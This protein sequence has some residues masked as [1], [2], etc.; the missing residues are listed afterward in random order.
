RVA[1]ERATEV[2]ALR[3][4]LRV[5]GPVVLYVGRLSSEKGVHVLLEAFGR[6]RARHPQASCLVVGPDWGPLRTVRPRGLGGAAGFADGYV[7]HLRRLAAPHGDRVLLVGAVPNGDLPLY[8]ALA[9]V[10]AVPSLLEAFG[11]PV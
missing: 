4:R 8:H 7:A 10:L 9:D 11:I 3:A 1:T 5:R 2:A 6:V